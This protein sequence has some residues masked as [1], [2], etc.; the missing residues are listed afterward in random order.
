M[1]TLPDELN[2]ATDCRLPTKLV[3]ARYCVST[4]TITR[5]RDDPTLDF[6]QPDV[7]NDR[8]YWWL[9]LLMRWER[10]RAA[11]AGQEKSGAKRI[12][13]Q[14]CEPKLIDLNTI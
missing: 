2:S 14:K 1:D 7:V 11:R 3:A 5:W 4:R 9:S 13:R 10:E 12:T 8:Q 6:P